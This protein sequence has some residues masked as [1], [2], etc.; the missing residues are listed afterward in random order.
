MA[1][2]RLSRAETLN[3]HPDTD[4]LPAKSLH[5]LSLTVRAAKSFRDLAGSFLRTVRLLGTHTTGA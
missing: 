2:L 4:P 3:F 1:L 5:R